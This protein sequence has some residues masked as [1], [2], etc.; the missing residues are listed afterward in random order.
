LLTVLFV[1][2]LPL[3]MICWGT[4]ATAHSQVRD[5]T[6][7]MVLRFFLGIWESGFFPGVVYFLTLF[8]RKSEIATRIALFYSTSVLSH[9]FAGILAY[10]ILQLRGSGGMAGWQWLFFIEGVPTIIIAIFAL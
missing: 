1:Y 8:Y 3:L 4:I 5:Y 7:L 10:Y 2:R 9:S 6:E